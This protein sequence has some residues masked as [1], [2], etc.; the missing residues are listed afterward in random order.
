MLAIAGGVVAQELPYVRLG[1]LSCQPL[2]GPEFSTGS[3][4]R[5][6]CQF[7]PEGGGPSETYSGRVRALRGVAA[8]PHEIRWEVLAPKGSVRSRWLAAQFSARATRVL[9][10]PVRQDSL[11]GARNPVVVLQPVAGGSTTPVDELALTAAQ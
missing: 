10:V 1:F 2:P 8:G 9:S 7:R 6:L 3:A 5:V 4:T 11:I